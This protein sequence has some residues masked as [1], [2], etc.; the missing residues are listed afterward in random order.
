MSAMMNADSSI[1]SMIGEM[2]G[3]PWD[4]VVDPALIAYPV[5]LAVGDMHGI[6]DKLLNRG[7]TRRIGNEGNWGIDHLNESL[8]GEMTPHKPIRRLSSCL[9]CPPRA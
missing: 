2:S 4:V 9:P 1:R 6:A 3:L 7:I 5:V 8:W